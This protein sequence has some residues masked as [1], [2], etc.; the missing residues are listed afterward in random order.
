[1]PTL[2]FA[3]IQKIRQRAWRLRPPL[4]QGVLREDIRVQIPGEIGDGGQQDDEA[5]TGSPLVSFV[6]IGSTIRWCDGRD[7]APCAWADAGGAAL[8]KL[9]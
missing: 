6:P 5:H 3:K 4:D 8:R 2:V 7:D 9:R 1:M